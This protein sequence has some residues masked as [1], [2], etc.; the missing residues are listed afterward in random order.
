MSIKTMSSMTNAQP[1][2]LGGGNPKS[3]VIIEKSPRDI[4]DVSLKFGAQ[5]P[6]IAANTHGMERED[7]FTKRLTMR[8]N[9][10]V[11]VSKTVKSYDDVG[12]EDAAKRRKEEALSSVYKAHPVWKC[13]RENCNG[14]LTC[15]GYVKNHYDSIDES[16]ERALAC[17]AN[18]P[19]TF[20][21][22]SMVTCSRC[23][24]RPFHR[25]RYASWQRLCVVC[26]RPFAMNGFWRK[27]GGINNRYVESP[28]QQRSHSHVTGMRENFKY[29]NEVQK[30]DSMLM[31]DKMWILLGL[32]NVIDISSSKVDNSV[33]SLWND[34]RLSEADKRGVIIDHR[35]VKDQ[36]ENMTIKKCFNGAKEEAIITSNSLRTRKNQGGPPKK[37]RKVVNETLET[38]DDET[39]MVVI[40]DNEDGNRQKKKTKSTHIPFNEFPVAFNDRKYSLFPILFREDESDCTALSSST[41]NVDPL[42]P[43][44]EPLE[45]LDPLFGDIFMKSSI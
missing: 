23:G 43:D 40:D 31:T 3:C 2:H 32:K 24:D 10:G 6:P 12:I 37:K 41:V 4:R 18:Y 29:V 33:L 42:Y 39:N 17:R 45:D 44:L 15:I 38:N 35:V 13:K 8:G 20:K 25:G 21:H 28:L 5:Y 7:E 30:I 9:V 1:W 16:H 26:K 11:I 22:G 19:D 27:H 34:S 36:T 14:V